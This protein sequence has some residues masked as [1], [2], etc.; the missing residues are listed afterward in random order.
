MTTIKQLEE[1]LRE[2]DER[3]KRSEERG[4]ME[5]TIT[6]LLME[7]KDS[8]GVMSKIIQ[9]ICETS[10]WDY[11]AYSG[12]DK[13]NQLLR[14]GD[15][16]S[17]PSIDATEFIANT[18]QETSRT[19]DSPI[20]GVRRR[21]WIEAAPIWASD[22]TRDP[23][24]HRAA[25]AAKVGLH[26]ALAFPV[27]VDGVAIGVMEFYSR[28]IRQQDE[29]LLRSARSIG[30]QIGQFYQR[31]Q[32]EAR[33]TMEH[34]VTRLLAESSTADEAMPKIIQ[35]ICETLGWDYG[36][37]WSLDEQTQLVS[38]AA[39][40]NVPSMDA[41]EFMAY[42]R[43]KTFPVE[44]LKTPKKGG[45][46]MRRIW[47]NREPL[48]VRDVNEDTESKRAPIAA[49]AGLHSVFAFPI[50]IGREIIGAMEFFSQNI[51][52]PDEIL[53]ETARSIGIQIGQFRQRKQAEERINI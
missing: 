26:A 17:S 39:S 41:A 6:R 51:R 33:Q 28:E 25:V 35:T 8:T 34:V 45:G 40:W 42:V 44:V 22:V 2:S 13:Q 52:Q 14:R 23:T 37:Y 18:R 47:D 4:A 19:A 27:L 10:G 20:G 16:W 1:K 50:L 30:N 31:K 7:S 21:A 38:C 12:S 24:F 43:E 49:K 48:W 29:L 15:T 53:I 36:G 11:G 3:F 9:T 32:I 5:H 46:F